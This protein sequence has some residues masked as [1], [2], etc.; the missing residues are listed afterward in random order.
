MI[1]AIDTNV[2]LDILLPDVHYV[3]ASKKLIDSAYEQ[4]GLIICEVVYSELAAWFHRAD[5]L[6]TFLS[7]TG[8]RLVP[9]DRI[10]LHAAAVAWQ[11]YTT[12]RDLRLQCTSCGTFQ[13]VRCTRC[14]GAISSCQH[15][16][17]DFIIGAHAAIHADRLL[18]RDRGFYR[19]YF[20]G[21][22]L[23]E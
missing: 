21:L 8:I 6:D 23:L 17:P 22:I 20:P 12:R 18:T 14:G 4:G 9:S 10:S 11:N 7:H 19:T 5:G 1:S 2:L 13:N 3:D 15:I 16:I